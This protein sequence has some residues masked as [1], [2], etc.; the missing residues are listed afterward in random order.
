MFSQM[1]EVHFF[2]SSSF[3]NIHLGVISESKNTAFLINIMSIVTKLIYMLMLPNIHPLWNTHI[4]Y[5]SQVPKK[6]NYC[7]NMFNAF[8]SISFLYL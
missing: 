8:F 6:R 4:F 2:S 3:E 7:K 5:T 1:N